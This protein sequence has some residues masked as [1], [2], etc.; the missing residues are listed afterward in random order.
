MRIESKIDGSASQF[1]DWIETQKKSCNSAFAQQNQFNHGNH[2]KMPATLEEEDS[3][4][5]FQD[6]GSA[7]RILVTDKILNGTYDHPLP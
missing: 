6:I 7:A 3:F 2:Q 4:D 5:I 1:N